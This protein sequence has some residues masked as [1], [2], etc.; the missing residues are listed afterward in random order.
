MAEAV[1]VLE[2]IRRIGVSLTRRF[3]YCQDL[4][5]AEDYQKKLTEL[6]EGLERHQEKARVLND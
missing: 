5:N 3:K 6:V 2:Q 1:V 4:G